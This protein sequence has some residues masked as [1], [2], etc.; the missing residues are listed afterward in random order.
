MPWS[1]SARLLLV[2]LGLAA[3]ATAHATPT[4]LQTAAQVPLPPE[5]G[6]PSGPAATSGMGTSRYDQVGL[7]RQA[8]ADVPLGNM[9]GNTAAST[10]PIVAG[11]RQLGPGSV[12]EVTALD[13]GRTILVLID[14]RTDSA[15]HG[16]EIELSSAAAAMLSL[17]GKTDVPVRVRS[18]VASAADLGELKAGRPAGTR[19]DAPP[20]L[21][22]ALRQQLKPA[23]PP[24]A[25]VAKPPVTDPRTPQRS[26]AAPVRAAVRPAAVTRQPTSGKYL[27]QVAALSN[28]ARA[29]A[30]AQ[31][32]GGYVESAGQMHRVRLGPFAD[33]NSAQR[34]RDAAKGR[35]YGDATIIIQP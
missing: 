35:G 30:L 31:T 17:A 8:P 1:N 23:S 18:V 16:V 33:T 25:T 28:A 26:A 15:P 21:L 5:A 32:L 34:A 10:G 11:H 14:R 7:A 3:V 4:P 13:T 24:S 19:L 12:A 22:A 2:A 9:T 20:A 6:Q 29:R 27:V